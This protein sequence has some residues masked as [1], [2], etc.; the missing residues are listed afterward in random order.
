MTLKDVL[1]LYGSTHFDRSI[2]TLHEQR[3]KKVYSLPR[4][5]LTSAREGAEKDHP[6]KKWK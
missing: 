2:E 5:T 1:L 6:G 3:I 4:T